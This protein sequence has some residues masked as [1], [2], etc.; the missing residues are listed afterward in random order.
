MAQTSKTDTKTLL[1][2]IGNAIT[3][4]IGT[5]L[6]IAGLVFLIIRA[7]HTGSPMRVVTFTVY[8]SILILFYLSSTL[9]HALVFTKAKHLFQIFDHC[10]IYILIAG[11]Y[12]PYCL[13]AIR[14]WE[15]WTMF[16]IIWA[17]A[18]LGVV[19]KSI[20]LKH[21]SNYSTLIYVLMGWLC[22]FAFFPLWHALGPVGFG[23]LLAGGITFTLGAL[24]YSR[25]TAYTHFIWHFFVLAGTALMYFSI[26]FYV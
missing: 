24:L 13:V 14:G 11:T 6:A 21:K 25:P 7:A 2:E 18:V 5:A 20:W 9:F 15:G 26:L 22:V 3:H 8:G 1:I 19:Y 4:G 10:M 23:L 17:L 12:T 16:G